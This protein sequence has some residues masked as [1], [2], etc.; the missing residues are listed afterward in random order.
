MYWIL[1]TIK[2]AR[3]KS[4]SNSPTS[5]HFRGEIKIRYSTQVSRRKARER[6]VSFPP[7]EGSAP[8][9]RQVS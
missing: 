1:K 3:V 9:P 6:G 8:P 4:L 5:L 7:Q 2:I